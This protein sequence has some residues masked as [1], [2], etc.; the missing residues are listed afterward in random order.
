MFDVQLIPEFS[1]AAIDMPIVEWTENV[2][3]LCEL[4]TMKNVERV[5]PLR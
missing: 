3:L 2:E 1:G 4:W 5:L